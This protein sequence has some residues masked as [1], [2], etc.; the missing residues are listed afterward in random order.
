MKQNFKEVK[1]RLFVVFQG[2]SLIYFFIYLFADMD[3]GWF[4]AEINKK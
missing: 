4:E 2:F 1:Y 3:C